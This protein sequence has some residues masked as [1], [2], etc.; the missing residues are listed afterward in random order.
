MKGIELINASAGTGKTYRLTNMV[1]E[2]FQSGLAPEALMATTYTNKAADELRERIRQQL[3][4]NGKAD[5]AQRIFDGFV[6]TV[7]SVCARFLSEYALDAGLSPALDVLPENDSKRLFQIAISSVMAKYAEHLEPVASR[8]ERNGRGTK[9]QKSPD[10]REDVQKIVDLARGNQLGKKDLIDCAAKSWESLSDLLGAPS[11]TGRN[12]DRAV[13][14]AISELEKIVEPAKKT[15]KCL[16]PLKKFASKKQKGFTIPWSDWLRLSNLATAKDAEGILDDVTCI[17]A[18]VLRHP[19]FQFDIRQMIT[20][21]FNCAADALESYE[22]FKQKQGLMDFV[23]QETKVLDMARDNDAFRSSIRDRLK[24]LMVD[25][26]QDTSPIQLA[27]FLELNNLVGKST[28]VGDPKQA[29]Y[30][31]RGTDSQLM[32][33]ATKLISDTNTLDESWRSREILV[34]FTNAIF[35]E[36]FH[37]MGK[38]K[39][40]LKIPDA[41]KSKANGGWIEAWNLPVKN[42]ANESSAIANGVKDLLT[43]HRDMKP[44]DIAILCWDNRQCRAI[45]KELENLGIR[46]SAPQGSL[47][48]TRECRLAVAALRHMNDSYDTV[49]LAE[50]VH[51][52]PM[53]SC[54][55]QWLTSLVKEKEDAMTQWKKDPLVAA[56]EKSRVHLN[57]WTPLEALENAI[58]D[59][60]LPLTVKSWSN[61]RIRMSNLDLLRGLCSEYL[62]Q[63]RA[64]RGAATVAGFI[65]YLEETEPA[66]AK[67]SGEQTVQILTYHGA[68]GLEWPVVIL[69][70]L[71]DEARGGAFGIDVIPAPKFNP[72]KPLEDRSIHYWPWPFGAQK[73]MQELVDALADRQEEI[74]AKERALKESR[75]LMYVGMTRACDGLIF[76]MRKSETK[77][78]TKLKTAWLDELTD[79]AGNPILEWP[80]QTGEQTLTIGSASIVVT[81]HEFNADAESAAT[82]IIKDENYVST[83]T[84]KF[85]EYPRARV[86]PSGLNVKDEDLKELNIQIAADFGQRIKLAGKP[87][88]TQLG[89]AIHGFLAVD[90]Y[91]LPPA[92]QA[93]VA[94]GLLRRWGVEQAI[95]PDDL[96]VAGNKLKSFIETNYHEAKILREWPISLRNSQN[97]RVQ[98]WVDIILELPEGY[99]VIDHKSYSGKNPQEYVKKYAPQL[100]LYKDAIEKAT[101]KKVIKTLL[102]LPLLGLVLAVSAV[103]G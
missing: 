83:L 49:A 102:H 72:A 46:A 57:H 73:T 19:D 28:W 27:L 51:L 94:S 16:E 88:M 25:E 70:S 90:T 36:V 103:K 38:D 5:E 101:G 3:L 17:A 13:K 53:H 95:S 37:E 64:R 42:T 74:N 52:S 18:D 99:V 97:Q 69:A 92:R 82:G 75:R 60:Q 24:Q 61:S 14:T 87:D 62:D 35:T 41:R 55:G 2:K 86:S 100:T 6:G 30:G 65:S 22:T 45:A 40:C 11:G 76:A 7:N 54:H 48:E 31:F 34:Q 91:D 32:D 63:C 20:G 12:L 89:D 39:V 47:L 50:I 4:K 68:K 80:M 56:L 96:L 29:I 79:S 84:D 15:Q 71:D 77:A 67:G 8:L 1:V 81:V 78:E 23:D 58:G 98:G 9:F 66:Q 59:V 93:E 33:E 26:F 10:W 85:Q 21:V 43:C 44:G